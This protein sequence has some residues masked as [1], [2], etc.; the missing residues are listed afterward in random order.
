MFFIKFPV[1]KEFD[2]HV[3]YVKRQIIFPEAQPEIQW[4]VWSDAH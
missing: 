2:I 1:D 3:R 4:V